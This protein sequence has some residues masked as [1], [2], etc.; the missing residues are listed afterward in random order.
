MRFSKCHASGRA[1]ISITLE[2]PARFARYQHGRIPKRDSVGI[3]YER[4]QQIG[5]DASVKISLRVA[6][7]SRTSIGPNFCSL[8]RGGLSLP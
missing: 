4:I 8:K 1:D 3:D 7:D 5:I 6:A 2:V